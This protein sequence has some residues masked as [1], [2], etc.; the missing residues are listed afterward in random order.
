MSRQDSRLQPQR[1]PKRNL[2][3]RGKHLFNAV[4]RAR[5]RSNSSIT[6]R[7]YT[8]LENEGVRRNDPMRLGHSYPGAGEQAL[9]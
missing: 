5:R 3:N 9:S 7:A 8:P 1:V 2:I 6:E 4:S